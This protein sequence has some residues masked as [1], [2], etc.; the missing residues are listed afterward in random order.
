MIGHTAQVFEVIKERHGVLVV[1]R[2]GAYNANNERTFCRVLAK[3]AHPKYGSSSTLPEV[4]ELGVVLELD[5]GFLIWIGSLHYQA[6]NQVEPELGATVERSS[7]G[8]ISRSRPNADAQWSHPSGLRVTVSEDG[9]ELPELKSPGYA[10]AAKVPAVVVAHPSGVTVTI[11]KE[12]NVSL[13]GCQA[14]TVQGE[15]VEIDT[16]P[17]DIDAQSFDLLTSGPIAEKGTVVSLEG[18][19]SMGLKG[20]AMV[21]EGGSTMQLNSPALS[22]RYGSTTLT[23]ANLI[24]WCKNHVHH[25]SLGNTG[26]SATAFPET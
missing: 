14:I 7:S 20:P 1:F 6:D 9:L 25:T 2:D 4:G 23:L 18:T 19:T 15:S 11:S 10:R 22:F 5:G 21:I 16:G 8:L 12:G 3:R 26:N 13:V 17:V 24:S